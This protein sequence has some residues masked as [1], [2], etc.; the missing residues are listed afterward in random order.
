MS[1]TKFDKIP[2]HVAMQPVD[3]SQIKE[4]GHDPQA[5]RLYIRFHAKKGPG[6]VY[7][8]ENVPALNY[9]HLLGFSPDDGSKIDGHS[10]GRHF[11]QHFKSNSDHPFKRLNLDES[12]A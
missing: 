9:Q 11:G 7:S 6:S 4:I 5:D 12:G 1:D 2:G 10:I 8:Y 3:S